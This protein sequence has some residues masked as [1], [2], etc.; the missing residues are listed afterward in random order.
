[1]EK[2]GLICFIVIIIIEVRCRIDWPRILRGWSDDILTP[3]FLFR[4]FLIGLLLEGSFTMFEV[5]GESAILLRCMGFLPELRQFCLA[6]V[7]RLPRCSWLTVLREEWYCQANA[8]T[9]DMM[10]DSFMDVFSHLLV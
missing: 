3:A 1:L 10:F 5:H 7:N 6:I 9:T 4:L 2:V 8:S